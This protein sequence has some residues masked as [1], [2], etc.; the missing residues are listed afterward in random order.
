MCASVPDDH[1]CVGG[2]SRGGYADSK[3]DVRQRLVEGR[4]DTERSHPR[5]ACMR[6]MH[7]SAQAHLLVFPPKNISTTWIE[8]RYGYTPMSGPS[9]SAH[10]PA[11]PDS[12]ASKYS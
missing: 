1:V 9:P 5:D 12:T 3:A 2:G 11:A 4:A 8:S 6:A 10:V 7:A